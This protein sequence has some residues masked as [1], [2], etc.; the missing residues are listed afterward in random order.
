[1][2]YFIIIISKLVSNLSVKMHA[3]V[4]TNNVV[5]LVGKTNDMV[6]PMVWVKLLPSEHISLQPPPLF[7]LTGQNMQI[8]S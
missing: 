7:K 5:I 2:E 3:Y 4:R 1:M 6:F 8:K